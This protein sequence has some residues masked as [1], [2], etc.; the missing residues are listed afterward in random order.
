MKNAAAYEKKVKKLLKAM[1]KVP[2]AEN[3]TG[4]EAIAVLIQSILEANA[5]KKEA[6]DA[7]S[8]IKNEVVDFNELRVSPPKDISDCIGKEFPHARRKAEMISAILR[9]IFERAACNMSLDYMH[10]MTKR[11]LRRH[12]GEMGLSPYASARVTQE[13]FGGHAIPVDETLVEVLQMNGDVHPESDLADVQGFLERIIS[14]KNDLAANECFRNYIAK[15]AKPLAK[16]R[17][18]EAKQRAKEEAEA[19]AKAEAEAKAKAE[20]E[21]RKAVKKAEAEARKAAKEKAAKQAARKKAAGAKRA[22]KKAEKKTVKKTA[23]RTPAKKVAKKAAKKSA[24]K[25]SKKAVKKTGRK[26]TKQTK[27]K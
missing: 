20:A 15:S 24:K 4:D 11:D 13:V 25:V 17:Q 12:L 9:R 8:A 5:T 26:T 27:K 18:A 16:K 6:V 23:K 21:A 10:A 7:L 2:A 19:K 3:P 14:Q 1:P 22:A